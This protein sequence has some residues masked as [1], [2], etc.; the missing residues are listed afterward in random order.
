MAP[1]KLKRFEM[2]AD[3]A[4]LRAVDEW[5]RVQQDLPNR[6]EAIRRLVEQALAAQP[7]GK[8]KR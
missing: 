8:P 4:F 3:D 2:R 6:S 5:R 7:R 1:E